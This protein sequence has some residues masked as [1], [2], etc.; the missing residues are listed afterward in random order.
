MWLNINPSDVHNLDELAGSNA[1][2][3]SDAAI[4]ILFYHVY[5]VLVINKDTNTIKSHWCKN[6]YENAPSLFIPT[7]CKFGT[8]YRTT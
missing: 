2:I 1:Y 7:S 3:H 5:L 8:L 6:I 4:I